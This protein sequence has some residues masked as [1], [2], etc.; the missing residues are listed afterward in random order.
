[1]PIR[2]VADIRSVIDTFRMNYER[3]SATHVDDVGGG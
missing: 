2:T 1:V 3:S